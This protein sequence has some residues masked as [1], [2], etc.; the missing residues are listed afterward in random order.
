MVNNL[1]TVTPPKEPWAD[2][3]LPEGYSL[4]WQGLIQ[5]DDSGHKKTHI[6][7]PVWISAHT[8]DSVY[9]HYGIVLSFID[10]RGRL[11]EL[12]LSRDS[13]YEQGKSLAQFLARRGL[14]IV[15]G[16]EGKLSQYLVRF[17][18]K[19][20]GWL[21]STPKIGW[22]DS[23]EGRL[24]YVHPS[25]EGGAIALDRHERVIFQPEQHSPTHH[26]MRR[27]GSLADWKNGPAQMCADNPYL[28]GSLCI[29]LTPVLLKA[30]GVESGGV[31]FYGR[32]SRGKTT[33]AQV[34]ASVW[35][36]GADPSDSPDQAYIQRWS[37]TSNGLEGLLAG[38][39]D[40]LLVLDEI[41]TCDTKDFGKVVYNL[42][43]GKGKVAMDK[44]RNLRPS[45]TW[46][47]FI[48]STGEISSRQKIEEDNKRVHAGQG[49][50]LIDIPVFDNIIVATHGADPSDFVLQLKR[51]CG[52]NFG[53]AGP[54]FIQALIQRFDNNRVITT[55]ILDLLEHAENRLAP[56][57]LDPLQRRILRRF[58]LILV[59]GELAVE[60]KILPFEKNDI[61]GAI[62]V[63]INAWIS[64]NANIPD[65]VRGA[66]SVQEFIQRNQFKFI[67]PGSGSAVI[68]P[69]GYIDKEPNGNLFLFTEESFAKACGGYDYKE[70]ARELH[71]RGFLHTKEHGR[72]N[73]R[74]T[75]IVGGSK[76][77]PRLFAVW[78]KILEFHY[79]N[80]ITSL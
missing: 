1:Q 11:V 21:S 37:A 2:V 39:N 25:A 66:L 18:C 77:R 64:E 62:R 33:A 29:A 38:H 78:D 53:V 41:H 73:Y 30:A 5:T 48:F 71:R 67:A 76:L 45:R 44:N 50:R 49:V 59:A 13:L 60:F 43:G 14:H 27:N 68:D 63:L 57:N 40:S 3:T 46:R 34:A 22:L 31:H 52:Q 75:I 9:Q 69:V 15:H 10:L 42:A 54:A 17:D 20:E 56:A 51:A 61:E 26:S 4:T 35:G 80:E 65:S 7:G 28:M 6:S 19:P 8:V 24:I 72:L 32:S 55:H 16:K 70:V 58:A 12:A 23:Q 47:I 79:T 36:Y 74:T